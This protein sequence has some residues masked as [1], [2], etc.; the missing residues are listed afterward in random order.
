MVQDVTDRKNAQEYFEH[1]ATHDALT[2]LPN[3]R[4]F[5]ERLSLAM[6]RSERNLRPLA[7]MFLDLNKFKAINDT[8][9][10][11][12]GDAV[13]IGF[14]RTLSQCVRKT[15]TVARLAGDEFIILAEEL[16]GG[17]EDAL[18]VANK[19]ISAL[20]ALD[21]LGGDLGLA[22]HQHRDRALA[23]GRQSGRPAGPGRPRHVR[24]QGTG[25]QSLVDGV[26]RKKPEF[27]LRFLL[28][29]EGLLRCCWCRS[30]CRCCCRCGCFFFF[31]G[32]LGFCFVLGGFLGK[33]CLVFLGGWRCRG[34]FGRRRCWRS[35]WGRGAWGSCGSRGCRGRRRC[36]GC[37][38]SGGENGSGEQTGDQGSD[39]FFMMVSLA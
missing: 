19:I 31:S 2:G 26:K 23:A 37:L 21:P 38:A 35:G 17:E 13:L 24:R 11:A 27:A 6:A 36:R 18:I 28:A 29:A 16:F 22:G 32:W 20:E 14:G 15:D 4:A 25:R 5:M 7:L 10:H 39:Y 33:R 1:H 8:L 30:G 9:G 34:C 3:R 12:A